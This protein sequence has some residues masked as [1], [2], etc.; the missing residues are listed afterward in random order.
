M[1]R[2]TN[3]FVFGAIVVGVGSAHIPSLLLHFF[4]PAAALKV[5]LLGEQVI[6]AI[7]KLN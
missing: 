3:Q 4:Y 5:G 2:Y 7:F 1:L 6:L